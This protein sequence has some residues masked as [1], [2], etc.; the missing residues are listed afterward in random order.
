MKVYICTLL[1]IFIFGTLEYQKRMWTRLS[2]EET[3]KLANGYLFLLV[4]VFLFVGG[5]R[6]RVGTD[7]GAYAGSY[8]GTFE[9]ILFRIVNFDEPIIYIISSL[10]R[11]IWNEGIFV[12]F[13]ENAITVLLVI[14]GIRDYETESYVLPLMFYV[15]YCGWTFSFNGIRQAMA[16]ALIFAFS[17]RQDG[18][19]WIIKYIV[20]CIVAFLIH[21]SAIF[22]LPILIL[23][24]RK[25]DFKQVLII[26]GVAYACPYLGEFAL[27][28][29]DTSLNTEYAAH[30]VNTIRVIVSM[31]P[32]VLGILSDSDFKKENAFLMNMAFLNAFITFTTRNSALMYRFSS[33]TVM[34]LMLFIP[35]C[36]N[37]FTEQSKKLYKVLVGVLFFLYFAYEI[38]SG[39]GNLSDFQWAF[40]NFGVY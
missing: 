1:L 27:D 39:N 26:L 33:Y 37:I 23:A 38:N 10:C 17:K 21:K 40:G 11:I 12:I 35:K 32:A 31:A 6:F 34:Y 8:T 15:M 9:E 4:G 36:A 14:K 3:T 18:Q 20:I 16:G 2:Y 7:Y 28:F 24:N 13:V 19:F 29:M 22:M 5:F 25:I 30:S